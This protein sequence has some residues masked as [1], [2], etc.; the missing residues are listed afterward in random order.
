MYFV[1]NNIY[2]NGKIMQWMNEWIS[3]KESKRKMYAMVKTIYCKKKDTFEEIQICRL[4]L[5]VFELGHILV[6]LVN[7]EN[8]DEKSENIHKRKKKK[9]K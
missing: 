5:K 4:L 1:D 2:A 3:K 9:I 8:H 6:R 7:A